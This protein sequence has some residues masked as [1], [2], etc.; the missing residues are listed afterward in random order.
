MIPQ[1]LRNSLNWLTLV[2]GLFIVF[3]ATPVSKAGPIDDC[4][5]L[6]ESADGCLLFRADYHAGSYH[7]A[8]YGSFV[9]GNRVHVAGDH[10]P[11]CF[12]DCGSSCIQANSI[13]E[14]CSQLCSGIFNDANNDGRMNIGDVLLVVQFI[15]LDYQNFACLEQADCNLNGRIEIADLTCML[16]ILF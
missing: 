12:G 6:Y 10:N 14:G 2:L 5:F 11:N 16:D 1:L 4:G 9:A 8:Y 15:F 13:S 3:L 7:L